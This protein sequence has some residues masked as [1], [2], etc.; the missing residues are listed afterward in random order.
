MRPSRSRRRVIWLK[1]FGIQQERKR[2]SPSPHRSSRWGEDRGEGQMPAQTARSI[3]AAAT[4]PPRPSRIPAP[5][6]I[7]S[8]RGAKNAA[9][10]GDVRFPR[11]EA[12]RKRASPS[13]HRSSRW[14]EGRGE[15]QMPAQ[16]GRS[17]FAAATV[18]PK[19]LA[20]PCPSPYTLSPRREERRGERGRALPSRRGREETRIALS[21]SFFTMGR[22]SG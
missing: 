1:G 5:H 4:V 2:A 3:F 21:P 7:P 11:A 13:P 22:G 16:T 6:P 19:A 9:G 10:R 17:I 8:P 20:E 14:G 15:G 12:E 18:P